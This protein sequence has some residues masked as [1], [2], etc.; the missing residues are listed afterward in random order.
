MSRLMSM[1]GASSRRSLLLRVLSF[2]A[3]IQISAG[4]LAFYDAPIIEPPT[5]VAGQPVVFAVRTGGCDTIQSAGS[6]PASDAFREIVRVGNT[7]RVTV[8]AFQ[9]FGDDFCIFP[10]GTFRFSLGS[11]EPGRFTLGRL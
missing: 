6:P 5:P 10:V 11:L 4:A 3:L 8:N 9:A 1:H 2:A 7:L